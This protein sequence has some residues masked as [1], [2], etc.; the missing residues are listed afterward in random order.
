MSRERQKVPA[1]VRVSLEIPFQF[2][3]NLSR[4]HRPWRSTQRRRSGEIRNANKIASR[5]TS[6][7]GHRRGNAYIE[8]YCSFSFRRSFVVSSVTL[9]GRAKSAVSTRHFPSGGI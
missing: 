3:P 6:A 4:P 5:R 1:L 8:L 2:E 9:P 7:V